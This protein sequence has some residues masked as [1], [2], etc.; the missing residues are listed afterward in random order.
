MLTL[1]QPL[2]M[3]GKLFFDVIQQC[4]AGQCIEESMRMEAANTL[5][6]ADGLMGVAIAFAVPVLTANKGQCPGR[7]NSLPGRQLLSDNQCLTLIIDA[8]P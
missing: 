3:R 2:A 5:A 6:D 1:M 8:V 4:G 7:T